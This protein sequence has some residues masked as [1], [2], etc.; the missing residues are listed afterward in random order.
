L[1]GAGRR[2]VRDIVDL[3]TV[4][5]TILSLGAV[6]WAAVEESPGFSPE[7]LIA[8]IDATPTTPAAEWRALLSSE[9]LDPK[10]IIARLRI[11]LDQA[12]EFVHR[13]PTDKNECSFL[14]P[15]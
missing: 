8:Q 9:P 4:H 3:V 14:R 7:G 6:I 5:E 2:E 1:A 12:E 10:E 15:R 13:M 11:A